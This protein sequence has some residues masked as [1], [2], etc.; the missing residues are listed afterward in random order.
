M[1]IKQP[2]HMQEYSYKDRIGN[3]QKISMKSF[4]RDALLS[5]GATGIT[6]YLWFTNYKPSTANKELEFYMLPILSVG[7]LI[8][9]TWK[10]FAFING[11]R[12]LRKVTASKDPFF[13]NLEKD[14]SSNEATLFQLQ[15]R[16]K[17]INQIM[18]F[19]IFNSYFLVIDTEETLFLPILKS[20]LEEVRIERFEGKWW[21]DIYYLNENLQQKKFSTSFVSEE[22]SY[23]L[24][25]TLRKNAKQFEI[26]KIRLE[27]GEDIH[28]LSEVLGKDYEEDYIKEFGLDM[29][30]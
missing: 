28:Y 13:I 20:Q 11:T 19:Y 8:Y 5:I 21:L 15:P 2:F 30:R 4:I 9:V 7:A 27:K 1:T 18:Y 6:A 22:N 23:D 25:E 24:V 12:Y 26:G 14:I 17:Y 29:N 10:A 16:E 3:F